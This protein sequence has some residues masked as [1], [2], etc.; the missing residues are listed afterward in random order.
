MATASL[1]RE[2]AASPRQPPVVFSAGIPLIWTGS[3]GD[4]MLIEIYRY[5]TSSVEDVVTCVARDDGSFLVPG[6]AFTDWTILSQIT[7]VVG[8]ATTSDVVLPHNRGRSE[9]LGVAWVQGAGL[10]AI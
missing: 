8:R 2:L 7:F 10:Q 3:G 9:V 4:Y 6:S 1:P 5:G